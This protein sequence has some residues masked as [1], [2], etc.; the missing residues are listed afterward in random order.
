MSKFDQT[1]ILIGFINIQIGF[2]LLNS[3]IFQIRIN[4][5]VKPKLVLRKSQLNLFIIKPEVVF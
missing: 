4:K 1:W 3:W 2:K 5:P